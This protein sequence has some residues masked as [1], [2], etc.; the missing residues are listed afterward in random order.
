LLKFKNY[1]YK[2][3][4]VD[5]P[6]LHVFVIFQFLSGLVFPT[7]VFPSLTDFVL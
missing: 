1:N 2:F 7:T 6:F 5:Y 4:L 3:S